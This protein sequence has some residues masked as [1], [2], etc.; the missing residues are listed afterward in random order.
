MNIDKNKWVEEFVFNDE[1]FEIKN[2]DAWMDYKSNDGETI[3]KVKPFI[4]SYQTNDNFYFGLKNVD[5]YGELES[6]GNVTVNTA[7]TLPYLYAAIDTNNMGEG[8]IKFLLENELGEFTGQAVA[9]GY[10]EFPI[11]QFNEEK[12]NELDPVGFGEYKRNFEHPSF[13]ET[14]EEA[15]SKV[16]ETQE[17]EKEQKLD[18]VVV[19]F[20]VEEKL[21]NDMSE[22]EVRDMIA[23][24]LEELEELGISVNN[25]Y[26]NYKEKE[27]TQFNEK[28]MQ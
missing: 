24:K 13:E 7:I 9:S 28:E 22:K 3:Y 26:L 14:V 19:T 10:C 8:V 2:A 18:K 11:F 15:K 5:E 25:I 6:F 27:K 20:K 1:E 16:Q 23:R 12:L 17:L 21:F 4:A